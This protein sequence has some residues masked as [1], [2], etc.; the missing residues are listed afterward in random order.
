MGGDIKGSKKN[1][2][3]LTHRQHGLEVHDMAMAEKLLRESCR[4]GTNEWIDMA[5]VDD[6]EEL[7]LQMTLLFMLHQAYI[8]QY[9]TLNYLLLYS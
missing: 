5:V 1:L 6:W 8:L 3:D 7:L 2:K 4:L 9:S